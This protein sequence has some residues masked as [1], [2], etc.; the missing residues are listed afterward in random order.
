MAMEVPGSGALNAGGNA[1][2]RA[3]SCGSAGNC[4]AGGFYTD[5]SGHV[6]AFLA[7]EVNGH[8]GTAFEVS[9]SGGLNAGGNAQLFSVSCG[10]TGDCSAGGFYTD[11]S[12]HLQAFLVKEVNGHWGNAFEVS[13]SG[14]LNA[15]G[16]AQLRAVSCGSVGDCSAGGFYTDGSGHLQAF[17]VK[18]VNGHWGNAFEVS[19]S[20]GLNAG[21]NAQLVSVS[22]R[23]A[24]NCSAGGFYVDGSGHGQAMLVKEV[25]GHWGNAF[26]VSAS[27]GLNA[28]G[29]AQ[30]VSVSCG[31]AGDC[32][33][34]GFYTDG[35]GHGQAF[36]VKQV[37]AHWG[38]AFEVSASGALNAGGNAQVR[39]VSC[40]SAGN[41]SAG[42]FYTDGFSHVQ[43][44]LVKE[45]N[46][47]WGNAFEVSNSGNLN[48]GGNAQ[49]GA[50]SCG[51]AGNCSAGGFY[52]DGSG[53]FQAFLVTEVN[54]HW[55]N[56]FEVSNSGNLNAG[57]NAQL[58][59]MSCPSAGNCAAGGFYRDGSGNR[60]AFV[61]SQS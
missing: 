14:G 31:S 34:G 47:H 3:V 25:N 60:Q 10:S 28:G 26:E 52:V 23:S 16:D 29:N 24:G 6:Q 58:G 7:K 48:V 12:G 57:G 45:M 9:A 32:S 46:A 35:S 41:C 53:H 33:A 27:G 22:C 55:G 39:A 61:V 21:G 56:A 42:G 2:V 4:S 49:L 17:L 15:G 5:G 38:N 30:L 19:A 51:S 36:L 18:E 11:G 13:A 20:G 37:N 44:F 40:P 50:L 43:A 1:Q 54:S 8:W 59:A